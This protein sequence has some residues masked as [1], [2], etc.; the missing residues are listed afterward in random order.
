MNKKLY[1]FLTLLLTIFLAFISCS[2]EPCNKFID[3]SLIKCVKKIVKAKKNGSLNDSNIIKVVFSKGNNNKIY[4]T[5]RDDISYSEKANNFVL[6][7]YLLMDD[8]LI[9]FYNL[10]IYKKYL[11]K[12][13]TKLDVPVKYNYENFDS[14]S[15]NWWAFEIMEDESL[16]LIRKGGNKNLQVRF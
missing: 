6:D 5:I 1:Y 7:G 13:L 15:V 8:N 16:V 9:G 10:E 12:C 2:N 4:V 3:S 14:V 11:G